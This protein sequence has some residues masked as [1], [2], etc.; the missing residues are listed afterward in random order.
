M[1]RILKKAIIVLTIF[2]MTIVSADY[3][4][5]YGYVYG[6]E[7]S[8]HDSDGIFEAKWS[9]EKNETYNF[10]L[11]DDGSTINFTPKNNELKK[12]SISFK[13]NSLNSGSETLSAGAIK[14]KMPSN[15]FTG[16]NGNKELNLKSYGYNGEI[17]YEDNSTVYLNNLKG[18]EKTVNDDGTYTVTN[19]EPI[20]G[21]ANIFFTE[22]FTF[23]PSLV[24][25]DNEGN[26]SDNLK[27]NFEL[28]RANGQKISKEI[29]LSAKI[30]NE[31]KNLSVDLHKIMDKGDD[32]KNNKA[33]NKRVKNQEGIYYSWQN[34]WGSEPTDSKNFFYVVWAID[35]TR[36]D[37][38][39]PS[40][41]KIEPKMN[42][43]GTVIGARSAYSDY[44]YNYLRPGDFGNSNPRDDNS[45]AESGYEEIFTQPL[46]YDKLNKDEGTEGKKINYQLINGYFNSYD[47]AGRNCSKTRVLILVK[48]PKAIIDDAKSKG[49]DMNKDGLLLNGSVD[50]KT[51][52]ENGQELTANT[53]GETTVLLP[54]GGVT[55]I[56]KT[57]SSWY[58]S[59]SPAISIVNNGFD[60]ILGSD[61]GYT[62]ESKYDYYAGENQINKETGLLNT[63]SINTITEGS[64]YIINSVRGIERTYVVPI[65]NLIEDGT[66]K[67]ISQYIRYNKLYIDISFFK[68]IE[69]SVGTYSERKITD[70]KES[71]GTI[72]IYTSQ[73]REDSSYKKF[74][75]IEFNS[76]GKMELNK[77]GSNSEVI[78]KGKPIILPENTKG[79][80]YVVK[81]KA[82]SYKLNAKVLE[83]I[84]KDSKDELNKA[85]E[86]IKKED[87]SY[88]K[89]LL[90]FSWVEAKDEPSR[91][92][93]DTKEQLFGS[94]RINITEAENNL[95]A[96]INS[97]PITEDKEKQT[98]TLPIRF[99]FT[100]GTNLGGI[101]STDYKLYTFKKADLYALL[102]YGITSKDIEITKIT[103]GLSR[104]TFDEL[105]NTEYEVEFIPNYNGTKRELML[106]KVH[107]NEGKLKKYFNPTDKYPT[108][109]AVE[110][111]FKMRNT[112]DNILENGSKTT[113]DVAI[114]IPSDGMHEGVDRVIAPLGNT[115]DLPKQGNNNE[116]TY[117]IFTKYFGEGIKKDDYK[118]W[119][120]MEGELSYNS[121]KSFKDGLTQ[122]GSSEESEEKGEPVKNIGKNN[123]DSSGI[124]IKYGN[125]YEYKV[126]YITPKDAKTSNI[127]IT[128]N[129]ENEK[130]SGSFA[131]IKMLGRLDRI[132]PKIYYSRDPIK[133][134]ISP[135]ELDKMLDS[136]R[137]T[138]K[139]ENPQ[140]IVLDCRYDRSSEP[141][142][143]DIPSNENINSIIRPLNLF[144]S[145]S[146]LDLENNSANSEKLKPFTTNEFTLLAYTIRMNKPD[147]NLNPLDTTDTTSTNTAYIYSEINNVENTT[148]RTYTVNIVPYK[149]GLEKT[150]NPKYGGNEPA[151]I[152]NNEG[153]K[154]TYTLK[155]SNND[156]V[157]IDNI[158][159]SDSI[160]D[161]L[162]IGNIRNISITEHNKSNPA[163][164]EETANNSNSSTSEVTSNGVSDNNSKDITNDKNKISSIEIKDNKLTVTIEKLPK[165]KY[166]EVSIPTTLKNKVK[167]TTL[168]PNTAKIDELEGYT[169][170]NKPLLESNTVK[171]KLTPLYSVEYMV[172]ED[173]DYGLPS[174]YEKQMKEILAKLTKKEKFEYNDKY[175]IADLLTTNE[176]ISNK[177]GNEIKGTW[178]FEGWKKENKDK[179][180]E[181]KLEPGKE[182]TITDDMKLVGEWKFI[183]D[184][185]KPK[186]KDRIDTA[187]EISK[188]YYGKSNIVIVCRH[189]LYPDSLTATVLSKQ[190]DAPILLTHVNKLD[191]R[192][193]DEI[194]RL[195]ATH[196]IIVGGPKSVSEYVKEEIRELFDKNVERISGTDR[197]GTS[198]MVARRVVGLTGVLHKAV[199]ASGEVF[200]DAL[201]VSPFAAHNGYPILLI[202]YNQIPKEIRSAIKDLKIDK[203]YVIGGDNTISK[204]IYKKLPTPIERMAGID[205][206]ETAIK[207]AE[208]KF[209]DATKAFVASGEVFS[210]ALVI[211]PV[212]G[213]YND[214]VILVK[215]NPPLKI[216]KDY[217]QKSRLRN[218]EFVGGEK[219]ITPAARKYFEAN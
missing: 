215:K 26:A 181:N 71:P 128:N 82:Y 11:E 69:N 137:L 33:E 74:A 202:R 125:A 170:N 75:T 132:N 92:T 186:K 188:K 7:N 183:P 73:N 131:S 42:N 54:Q 153:T 147:S 58:S 117:D 16:W 87:P 76:E 48:Y 214:P 190:L 46:V 12:A 187:I 104:W 209:K 139:P 90:L 50:V 10:T 22:T 178:S 213:K 120:F 99:S 180:L 204:N 20:K 57:P 193:K 91:N 60:A 121:I 35:I 218:L 211:G 212:A 152:D 195:G 162:N 65:K 4:S 157:D 169:N 217:I 43:G 19:T 30:H 14:I 9:N 78:E 64:T 36:P 70:F 72:E 6:Q 135:V 182:V 28:T 116:P 129:L 134:V 110:V 32:T 109:N 198:E 206:Y 194:S 97:D 95:Y 114:N 192:V 1:Y 149:I 200:P 44:K 191:E 59:L 52:Y 80:R 199:V 136:G 123:T 18:F 25:V 133:R 168:I 210:D 83:S 115:Q 171:H 201:S 118:N 163:N 17:K 216:V 53:E 161:L 56:W 41:F 37:N 177:S 94:T 27:I 165:G 8:A 31:T 77:D 103:Y 196:V 130:N 144:A 156:T 122:N 205:R 88:S 51:I 124:T 3:S 5:R 146:S 89:K 113:L 23:L 179:T 164:V 21:D 140:A 203:T 81:S 127:I 66:F 85:L 219:T 158:K 145:R 174:D 151:K 138:T 148:N 24:K 67:D 40:R 96:I 29:N 208:S 119:G 45:I 173:P 112:T 93:I 38:L 61:N 101:Y 172:K 34:R 185:K 2:A 189:D 160:N 98:Q 79:L 166:I 159:V 86:N 108:S 155:I 63:E 47:E 107:P 102:P 175:R 197:Y 207:I 15:L 141:K 84:S 142:T 55:N 62:Y 176:S 13:V 100:N 143:S 49:I 68:A 126:R 39:I 150:S 184:K 106:I 154:V 167:E 111:S 105:N